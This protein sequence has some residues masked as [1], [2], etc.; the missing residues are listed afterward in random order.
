[1]CGVTGHNRAYCSDFFLGRDGIS[2][3]R[4][5]EQE[6]NLAAEA[7]AVE[8]RVASKTNT[9]AAS[10][11]KIPIVS[12]LQAFDEEEFIHQK[13]HE[14]EMARK[15]AVQKLEFDHEM[16]LLELRRQYSSDLLPSKSA[17]SPP[18]YPSFLASL[19]PVSLRL[20]HQRGELPYDIP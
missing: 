3:I 11:P 2:R 6:R 18:A 19:N 17:L 8:D 13:R 1:M 16:R 7:S 15:V 20:M 4:R 5:P 10:A 9:Q 12:K 14:A